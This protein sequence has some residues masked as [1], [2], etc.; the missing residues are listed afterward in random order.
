[1]DLGA[2]CQIESLDKIAIENG[3]SIP[4]LRGFRLMRDEEPFDFAG[5][6]FK[7]SKEFIEKDVYKD[8]IHSCPIFHPDSCVHEYSHWKTLCE[9]Y[10]GI[11][12]EDG[13]MIG[14][15]KDRTNRKVRKVIKM[16]IRKR[17]KALTKQFETFNKYVG[18]DDVL[19]I[20]ARIGGMN[21]YAYGGNEISQKPWFIEKVDDYFDDT[22]C[23]IYARIKPL[24]GEVEKE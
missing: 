11:F 21:W 22:Y 13:E 3:I 16:A 5:D 2:Y 18:R 1:M 24:N 20:H 17:L 4:R 10:Y 12:N 9:K 8:A 7:K 15:R 19:Y 23:D 14:I 6:D